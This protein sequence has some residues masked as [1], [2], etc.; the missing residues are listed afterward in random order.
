MQRSAAQTDPNVEEIAW[1]QEGLLAGV[2]GAAIVALFFLLV[3]IADGRALWTPF[4]L[5]AVLFRGTPPQPD[6][7][8]EP[9]LVAAYTVLHGAAFVSVGLPAAFLLMT[10]SRLPRVRPMRWTSWLAAF[11]FAALSAIFLAFAMLA[12]G[13]AALFGAGRIVLA[14]LLAAIAMAFTLDIHARRRD[15][16]AKRGV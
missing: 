8:I 5:G 4:A 14:N 15:V 13:V 12:P 3:D 11:L 10:T 1:V 6:T 7:P 2:A 9:A 16:D